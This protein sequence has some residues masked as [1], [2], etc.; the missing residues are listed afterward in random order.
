LGGVGSGAGGGSADNYEG[1]IS[2]FVVFV[3]AGFIGGRGGFILIVLCCGCRLGLVGF[4][5]LFLFMGVGIS[6]GLTFKSA[7]GGL[8]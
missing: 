4:W 2:R 6:A 8:S 1:L 7:L 3:C 5:S